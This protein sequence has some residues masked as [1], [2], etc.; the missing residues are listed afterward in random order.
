MVSNAMTAPVRGS[1]WEPGCRHSLVCRQGGRFLVMVRPIN[2][3][4][5]YTC[6]QQYR[7]D[8]LPFR[9]SERNQSSVVAER[10]RRH[11]A[12]SGR[13]GFV[14]LR[15]RSCATVVTDS[16]GNDLGQSECQE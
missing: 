5:T 6:W 2:L 1:S 4:S 10:R 12:Q 15:G 11:C 9:G 16:C 3:S 7:C 14:G 8:D 13:H